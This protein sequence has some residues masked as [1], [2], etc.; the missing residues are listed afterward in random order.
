MTVA[1]LRTS[2]KKDRQN[3]FYRETSLAGI[4]SERLNYSC[5]Y[6]I[7]CVTNDDFLKVFM[8]IFDK[9]A[10]IKKKL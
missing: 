7:Y 6:M 2:Y 5:L 1:V 9:Y 8:N 4:L 3:L 10:P